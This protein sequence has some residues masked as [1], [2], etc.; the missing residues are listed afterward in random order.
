MK[1]QGLLGD[2]RF[3]LVAS[4]MLVF[5]IVVAVSRVLLAEN[6]QTITIIN[7]VATVFCALIATIFFLVVW[8]S[9]SSEDIS[10]KIW[11]QIVIGSIAWTVAEGIWAYYEVILEQEVPYPGPAD[12][13]W[14][15]G[16]FIMYVALVNQYRLF[17]T[18][19]SQQQKIIIAALVLVFSLI[20]GVLVL[21]PIVEDFD[22]Q[23]LLESLLNV[24]YPLSDLILLTLTLAIIFSLEQGRFASTWRLL[25]LG[26][27][28]MALG[29]LMFSYASL[30]EIYAPETGLNTVTLLVDTLYY[31]A[32]LTLGLGGYSYSLTTGSLQPVN[33]DIVLQSLTKSN[34]LIFIDAN[35]RI[36]SLSDNFANLVRSQT[37]QQYVK[38]YLNEALRIDQTVI[39]DLIKTTLKH[40]SLSMRPMTLQDPRSGEREVWVTAL[41]IDDDRQQFV[42][43][44][45]I[46]RTNLD[47]PLEEQRPLSQ[48]QEMLVNYYLTKTGTYQSEEN[49]VIK[50]YFLEQ[51][52][53]LYS[54]TQQFN[55]ISVA[56]KLLAYLNQVASQHDWHFTFTNQQISIPE[57]YEGDVLAGPLSTLIHEAKNFA[58]NMIDL[59]VVEQEM[60]ILDNNLSTASLSYIDK[61]GL[62]NARTIS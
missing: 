21:K 29:D 25:G 40:G 17:Q 48:E 35:G 47:M 55:G 57:E 60:K 24:A 36:I 44:A 59:K 9:T 23:Y 49:Q 43:I 50:T 19:P 2:Q 61:Y 12:L 37:T 6:S 15:F 10:K 16:Y 56:D 45:V 27:V 4:L 52:R 11:G 54:L 3:I 46:L 5:S 20:V 41:E 34:I 13:F 62:R 58:G 38:T 22:R 7:D 28:F 14:L 31:V 33:I 42:C 30:N 51:I 53:L 26:L 18:P 8:L 1:K 39:A 32:Y